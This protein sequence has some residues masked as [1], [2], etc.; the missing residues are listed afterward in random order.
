M[1][2]QRMYVKGMVL[3]FLLGF[4]F[5]FST[6]ET[7][8]SRRFSYN[9]GYEKEELILRDNGRFVHRVNSCTFGFVAAGNWVQIGD[10]LFLHPTK[11]KLKFG[12]VGRYSERYNKYLFQGDTALRNIWFSDT[13]SWFPILIIGD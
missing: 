7:Q 8:K 1:K 3:L 9:T 11:E 2:N 12:D 13:E 10:T 5:G 6:V 4:L